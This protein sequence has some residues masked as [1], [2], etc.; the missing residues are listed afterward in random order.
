MRETG[1]GA[2]VAARAVKYA[3]S[4]LFYEEEDPFCLICGWRQAL[5]RYFYLRNQLGEGSLER[6]WSLR[7]DESSLSS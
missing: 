1:S 3:M 5:R 2:I 7:K 4:R 6:G